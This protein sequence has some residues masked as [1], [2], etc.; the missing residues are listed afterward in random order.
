MFL[1][2][3][4][5]GS[6][7]ATAESASDMVASVEQL[8]SS[9][10]PPNKLLVTLSLEGNLFRLTDSLLEA[11]LDANRSRTILPYYAVCDR[12]RVGTWELAFDNDTNSSYL[13][14]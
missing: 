6:F 10:V 2:V 8:K 13:R 5:D 7:N 1:Q 12:I 14:S 3:R 4:K 11:S 9:G